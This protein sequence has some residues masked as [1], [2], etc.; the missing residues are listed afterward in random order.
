MLHGKFCTNCALSPPWYIR[1]PR[2]MTASRPEVRAF[3]P[4]HGDPAFWDQCWKEALRGRDDWSTWTSIMPSASRT[5]NR[6]LRPE[7][8]RS[9]S[10]A[11]R[12]SSRIRASLQSSTVFRIRSSPILH[13][14]ILRVPHHVTSCPPV[15]RRKARAMVRGFQM[16]HSAVSLRR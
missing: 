9:P 1:T 11:P 5:D 7:V 16:L 14:N 8:L 10:S 4:A 15:I 6:S 12:S 2:A 13:R 3:F